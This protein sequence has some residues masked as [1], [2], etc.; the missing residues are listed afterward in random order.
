MSE[1]TQSQV[2]AHNARVRMKTAKQHN[3]ELVIAPINTLIKAATALEGKRV[4]QGEPKVRPWEQEWENKLNESGDWVHV[5]AQSI[6]VRLAN[7]S[8]YKCDVSAVPFGKP[9]ELH[10]FEIKGGNKMKGVAKGILALKVAASKYPEIN[11]H[12]VW[13]ENGEWF[14]QTIK[15]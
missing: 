3:A 2:D 11:W 12:L 14:H 9:S 15:P 8:W 13:K 5:K 4:R 10:F 6:R 7:G 1:W